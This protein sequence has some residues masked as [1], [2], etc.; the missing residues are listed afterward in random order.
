MPE[1]ISDASRELGQR[2]RA[3]RIELACSQEEIAHLAGMNV[4]NYGKIE[5]GRG[6]PNFYTIVQVAAVLEIDPGT[7]I[8]GLS[9]D[10]LPDRLRPFTAADFVKE[11]RA[12]RGHD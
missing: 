8:A 11:R 7:L 4:S 12:R 6:N 9:A 10:S 1:P 2:I 5:R 3:R